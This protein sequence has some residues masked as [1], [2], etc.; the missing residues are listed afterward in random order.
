MVLS[1]T[2]V[3]CQITIGTGIRNAALQ[4]AGNHID[5]PGLDIGA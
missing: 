3:T 5:V 4:V 2:F 1:L